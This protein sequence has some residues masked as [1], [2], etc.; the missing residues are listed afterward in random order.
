MHWSRKRLRPS[1]HSAD[2]NAL[3]Q[4]RVQYLGKKGELTH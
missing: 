4:M 3:E 2:I 1:Q